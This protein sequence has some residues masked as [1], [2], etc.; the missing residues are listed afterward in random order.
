V[1]QSGVPGR[2]ILTRLTRFGLGCGIVTFGSLPGQALAQDEPGWDPFLEV[3]IPTNPVMT[4][5]A[6]GQR[7][8]AYELHL[9]NLTNAEVTLERVDVW[10]LPGELDPMTG[11][12]VDGAGRTPGTSQSS[13]TDI[14]IE[15]LL[16]LEGVA[17]RNSLLRPGL[18]ENPEAPATIGPGLGAVVYIWLDLEPGTPASLEV[19][20]LLVLGESASS[21]GAGAERALR[22]GW[23]RLE[24]QPPVVIGPPL[25]GGPW[26]AGNGPSNFSHHRRAI[27]PIG[28][29]A[30]I[31]QRYAID[32][33]LLNDDGRPWDTDQKSNEDYLGHGAEL[34]AV[35]DG[36]IVDLKDGI[37]EN[38]PGIESRAVPITVGTVAGNYII[39]DIGEGK[40]AFYAHLQPGSLRVQ[41]GDRVRRG[42][43]IGLLGNSGNSTAPH[44]HFHVSDAPSPLGAEG[45]PYVI[46][47]FDVI[48][49]GAFWN[50][51][52]ATEPV[53]HERELPLANMV[54]EFRP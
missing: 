17:L 42:D 20:H 12:P 44:L 39:L 6:D 28:G 4:V 25:K 31:A 18:G 37:P 30:R 23:I 45:I 19:E 2:P 7:R 38:I 21:S 41:R 5:P 26:I 53:R 14:P 24:S 15:P 51:R 32:Y 9:T 40:Y 43:V 8:A 13:I 34:L 46:D 16:S 1:T 29:Q 54:M 36:T 49:R 27:I 22:A 52:R 10:R 11:I 35:A 3:R 48:G 33:A 50:R 47:A